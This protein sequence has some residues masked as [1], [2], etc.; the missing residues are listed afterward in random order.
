VANICVVTI[1]QDGAVKHLCKLFALARAD[2]AMMREHVFD[3]HLPMRNVDHRYPFTSK[4][5]KVIAAG[6]HNN[7]QIILKYIS[8]SSQFVTTNKQM[9][10]KSSLRYKEQQLATVIST[11]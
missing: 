6:A 3:T 9:H 11:K 2:R 1:N 5:L 10:I 4:E 7:I 8:W